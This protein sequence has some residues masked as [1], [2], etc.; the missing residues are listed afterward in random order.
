MQHKDTL[1]W[2]INWYQSQCDGD[3][4]HCYG[5][6][7]HTIDNPGWHI[8]IDI[9]ETKLITKKFN[10]IDINHSNLNWLYCSIKDLSF[11]G[12]CGVHNLHE[13]LDIFKSWA[14][15]ES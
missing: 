14:E 1:M 3:W 15:L 13:V 10:I 7:I 8:Q 12:Y 4:E 2:L 11:H 5:I 6:K 9:S